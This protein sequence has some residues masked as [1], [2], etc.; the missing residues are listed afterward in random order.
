[1]TKHIAIAGCGWLGQA[2]ATQLLQ[3]KFKVTA[4]TTSA[5]KLVNLEAL[6]CY[7]KLLQL[8]VENANN[9]E[10]FNGVD[11]LII[12]ITPQIRSGQTDYPLKVKQLVSMANAS[13]VERIILLGST[14]VYQRLGGEVNEDAKLIASDSKVAILADA[15]QQVLSTELSSCVLRL[16]GLFGPKRH[17]AKFLAGKQQLEN[18]DTPVNLV[19]QTDVVAAIMHLIESPQ[20]VGI[21]NVVANDHPARAAF[22][23]TAC[24]QLKLPLPSFNKQQETLCRIVSGQKL[25]DTGF[26]YSHD[27][28]VASI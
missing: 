10:V 28:L 17:P 27:D 18:A 1:M 7:A 20:L 21:F 23:L 14:A 22:Y 26:S 3:Q 2:L 15:E 11:T 4:T 24:Q 5:E 25:V 8:P 19:H 6:G 9:S 12:S 16:A 13:G